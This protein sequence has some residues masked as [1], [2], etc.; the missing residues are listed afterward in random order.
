MAKRL[1]AAILAFVLVLSLVPAVVSAEDA[2]VASDKAGT[3]TAAAHK[4][5]ACG[6][7]EWLP[8]DSATTLPKSGHY[9][10]TKDVNMT[11]PIND[12]AGTVHI[13]L[14]GYVVKAAPGKHHFNTRGVAEVVITDC[15]AYYDEDQVYHAGAMTGGAD[16]ANGGGIA[17]IRRGGVVKLYDG[18]FTGNTAKAA[19]GAFCL[20]A[21]DSSLAG[22]KLYMADGE[23][24]NNQA[25]NGTAYKAGGGVWLNSGCLFEMTG[26]TIR[27]NKANSGGAVYGVGTPT[28]NISNA[29]L[30]GNQTTLS[31]AAI[32][33]DSGSKVTITDSEI[34]GN[35]CTN[36]TYGGAVFM[37]GSSGKLTLSGKVIVADNS[38]AGT[39]IADINMNKAATD[40]LYIQD[41]AAGSDVTFSTPATAAADPDEVMSAVSQTGWSV[42][43]VKYKTASGAEKFV[44][45][46][47]GDF[48]FAAGHN[49]DGVEYQPLTSADQLIAGGNYYL[50]GDVS[51]DKEANL[52]PG[53]TLNLCLNGHKLTSTSGTSGIC[54]RL[55]AAEATTINVYDCT[56]HTDGSGNYVAG[57]ITGMHNK[58]ANNGGGAFMIR[59]KGVLNFYQ[60]IISDCSAAV[61]GGAIFVNG[62]AHIYGGEFRNNQAV[63]GTAA[64]NGGAIFLNDQGTL[65]VE[66][67]KFVNNTT[68]KGVGGAIYATGTL[69][70]KNTEFTGNSAP[71]GSGGAIAYTGKKTITLEGTTFTGNAARSV[72]AI[73][74]GTSGLS[75]TLKDVTVTGN[76]NTT[77]YGAV[78]AVGGVGSL[79]LEGKVV[80][81]DNKG[82]GK[83]DLHL[84]KGAVVVDVTGLSA[85][86]GIA[87]ALENARVEA[88]QMAFTTGS[89]NNKLSYFTSN[90]AAYLVGINEAKQL[91]LMA[92]VKHVHC[93]CGKTDC[94]DPTH[95]QISY[96]AWT[97]PTSMPKTGNYYLMTDV[98]SANQNGIQ[99]AT[100]N[101]CL[102]GHKVTVA[103]NADRRRVYFVSS[104]T[105]MNIADCAGNG[106]VSGCTAGAIL[107]NGSGKNVEVNLYGGT[108]T[109]NH[110][111]GTGAT[112]VIQ[113]QAT[114]NMYGGVITDNTADNGAGVTVFGKNAKFFMYGGTIEGNQATAQG[115]GLYVSE[116]T[117]ELNAGTISANKAQHGGGFY[118]TG[119]AAYVNVQGAEVIGNTASSGGGGIAE[120]G[121]VVNL[122]A[123]K[124]SEN[125]ATGSGAALYIST[126]CTV[127]MTGGA[128]DKNEA[129]ST[130]GAVYHLGST[131]NYSG[132][133]IS[134]NTAK[135]GGAITATL[136]T[137]N[138]VN[139]PSMVTISGE[140][141]FNGNTA[142]SNAGTIY[143]TGEGSTVKFQG[144]TI[145]GGKAKNA[146]GILAETKAVIQISGG[147]LT[148]NYAESNGGAVYASTNT[149]LTMTG[150][151]VSGNTA[152]AGAGGI[153][154]LRCTASFNGGSVTGNTAGASGGVK[155]SGANVTI[156]SLTVSGNRAIGTLDAKTGK[157]T[158]GNAGGIE[159]GRAGYKKNNVQQWQYPSI[160][161][162]NIYLANNVSNAAAGGMLVQ[163][164]GTVF[165]MYGGTVTGNKS[166]ATSGG[167]G[168]YFST[169]S[170]PVVTGGTFTNNTSSNGAAIYVLNTTADIS[171]IVIKNNHSTGTGGGL[172]VTGKTTVVNV[173]DTQVFENTADNNAGGMLAL[174]Y[175]HLNLENVQIHDNVSGNRGGGLYY[176]QPG[177]GILKNVEIYNNKANEGGGLVADIHSHVVAQNLTVRD[178]TSE[179]AAGGIFT[180]GRLELTG[181]KVLNNTAKETGGGIYSFKTNSSVLV[182]KTGM[183]LTDVVISGNTSG[184][185]GGGIYGYVGCPTQLTNC[186][187]TDNT[188]AQE[189]GGL[190]AGGR[191]H[192]E[193][194]TVTGNTSG[195][196]GYAVY[197]PAAEY[198]GHSNYT[199]FK[200]MGG[201]MIVR[202]NEGG[203]LYLGE[204]TVLA[205]TGESLG[206]KTYVDITIFDGVLS[207]WVHGVYNYEGGDQHYILTAGDRSLTD[208]EPYGEQPQTQ[209]PQQTQ[210]EKKTGD[211]WLYVG[212]GAVALVAIAGVVL[213]IL[214][215]KK[216]PAGETK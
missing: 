148:G 2:V 184:G 108:F 3:H 33:D 95:A 116:G 61:G 193:S 147:K 28:I 135:N 173:K 7:T 12:F 98:V 195:G 40:T 202:D 97:D 27:D 71:S 164:D 170:R 50:A 150:G 171:N 216:S 13:C 65:T 131:G 140:A 81:R 119:N 185:Q 38:V 70:V 56:A 51:L 200:T 31:G 112:F 74:L 4:C 114:M 47:D 54:T 214:K 122:S 175:S 5:E 167:G 136:R 64:K 117:A 142:S 204:E 72:S 141:V 197:L 94:T 137:R 134:G 143:I 208:P 42:T 139:I 104:N 93:V 78:N 113:G 211:T 29:K 166:G 32:H 127:N 125:K 187:I 186:T 160:Y 213:V 158:G 103:E 206:E 178:N 198:D 145:S 183:F 203:D 24:S 176:S 189:G 92:A 35:T 101:L 22:G 207:Q 89:E 215:K 188:A 46:K 80:I 169:N 59:P 79:K 17:F 36:G 210:N 196:E 75:A 55:N 34:T 62:E 132:G 37:G 192:L 100:L 49:H 96:T 67:A 110:A 109:D 118:V 26:G 77:G 152:K 52:N 6:S 68:P 111:T 30:T 87:V 83:N 155:I 25:I 154:L 128:M 159:I 76:T 48:S 149:K 8:W 43:W 90:D 15:T 105:T 151:T 69:T 133:S 107:T 21:G 138:D 99:A 165:R 121:S 168:I 129:A 179:G 172:T 161:I 11:A 63:S 102:H 153:M 39:G 41:L 86:S 194:V 201:E 191:M 120:S 146:G 57:Q 60:G 10:L 85:G 73:N 44:D 174:N 20:Q 88:G 106:T 16:A 91:Y 130:G 126:D 209:Q 182:D 212:I 157:Y 181:S 162:Y 177:N 14:N 53:V 190:Y 156:S 84:Q 23:I 82:N 9:Y 123:G 199:G 1:L 180:R 163:S 66:N 58:S 205:V 115:G 144:G 45:Y 19:G 18:R 124:I